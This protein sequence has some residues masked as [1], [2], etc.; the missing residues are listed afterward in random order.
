MNKR[1][2]MEAMR[3]NLS[4]YD[5][6]P[7]EVADILADFEEHIA[8][9]VA[10]GRAEDEIVAGLGDPAALAAQYAD[11]AE[12]PKPSGDHAPAAPRPPAVTAGGVGRAVFAVIALLFFDLIVG[13]PVLATLFAVW[14]TL[15]AV[16]LTLAAVGLALVVAAFAI[17]TIVPFTLP[18][19]FLVLIGVSLLALTVLFCIG[20]AYLTKYFFLGVKAYAVAHA[21]IVKGGSRS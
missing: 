6:S 8:T 1:E 19:L 4:A 11:G 13:L 12:P 10:G 3:T 5:K 18:A 2:F 17:P 7:Q 16:A 21:K 15:W 14:I 9:G 20:M